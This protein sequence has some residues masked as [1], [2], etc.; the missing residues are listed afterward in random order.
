MIVLCVHYH[1]RVILQA[2]GGAIFNDMGLH[3]VCKCVCE[4]SSC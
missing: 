1:H 2:I 4:V 3:A